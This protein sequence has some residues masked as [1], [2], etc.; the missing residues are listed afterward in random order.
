MDIK[1][2]IV[3][4]IRARGPLVGSLL[5]VAL[6]AATPAGALGAGKGPGRDGDR[7]T[8]GRSRASLPAT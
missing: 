2:A 5:L 6:A 1:E 3:R 4:R 8:D 7:L